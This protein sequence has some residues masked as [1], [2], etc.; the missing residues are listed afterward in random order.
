VTLPLLLITCFIFGGALFILLTTDYITA[1]RLLL[2]VTG[3][4]NGVL[5]ARG[6]NQEKKQG[7]HFFHH[8]HFP[9]LLL[10]NY[11]TS[12]PACFSIARA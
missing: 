3:H 8:H 7:A 12:S 5:R 11:L 1:V 2:D 4:C 10:L 9:L 6:K